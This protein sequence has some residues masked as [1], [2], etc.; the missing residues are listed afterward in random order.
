MPQRDDVGLASNWTRELE[1]SQ[2]EF[3]ERIVAEVLKEMP[4]TFDH[5]MTTAEIA[6]V[7]PTLRAVIERHTEGNAVLAEGIMRSLLQQMHGYGPLE[8]LFVGPGATS[9]TEIQITPARGEPP[10]VFV[11]R[12]GRRSP[13]PGR[14]SRPTKRYTTGSARRRTRWT[15]PGTNS[16]RSPTSGSTTAA[17]STRWVSA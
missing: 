1:M 17:A 4:I 9:I 13:G 10:R 5:P 11:V 6:E 3:D 8:P 7:E 16:T 12:E 15:S 2:V 14:P